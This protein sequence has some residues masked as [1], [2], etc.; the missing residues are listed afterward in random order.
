MKELPLFTYKEAV[1]LILGFYGPI[2]GFWENELERNPEAK[3]F[4][5]MGYTKKDEDYN[6]L[7]VSSESGEQLLHEYIKNISESFITYMK[8]KGFE[9]SFEDTERWFKDELGLETDEDGKDI[10]LFIFR[11]LSHYGYTVGKSFSS[12]KG[13]FYQLDRI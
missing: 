8:S 3:R 5:E 7:Y 13:H 1:E 11:N 6:D 2:G 4:V 9:S 12:R 10:A